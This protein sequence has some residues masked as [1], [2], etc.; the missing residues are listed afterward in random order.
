MNKIVQ[1]LK[2]E[3]KTIKKTQMKEN[4]R[5]ITGTIDTSITNRIQET[6]ERISCAED[7]I[8]ES[9]MSVK[10]NAKF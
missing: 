4:L 2:M 8:E 9:D 1:G 7:T 5:K 6:E 3:I 10:A